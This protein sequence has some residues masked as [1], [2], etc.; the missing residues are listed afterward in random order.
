ML[1]MNFL[2]T[3]I[4][5]FSCFTK[6]FSRFTLFRS[7]FISITTCQKWKRKICFLV[8]VYTNI[9]V[10]IIRAFVFLFAF[11][12][13]T[14]SRLFRSNW[15]QYKYMN[16]SHCTIITTAFNNLVMIHKHFLVN[17][18]ER[19]LIRVFAVHSIYNTQSFNI[20]INILSHPNTT[21]E[22]CFD[23]SN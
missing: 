6:C 23:W 12:A 7:L 1:L 14:R 21:H 18:N 20:N 15:L 11:W 13:L 16:T 9:Y 5:S 10:N 19:M 17:K 4:I 2:P 3:K 22:S 8:F